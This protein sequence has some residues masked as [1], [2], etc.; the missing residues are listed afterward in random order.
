MQ[1]SEC[2]GLWWLPG[3]EAD[4]IAGVLTISDSGNLSLSLVGTLGPKSPDLSKAHQIILGSVDKSPCG[5]DVTL[6][7]C[8]LSGSN[9]GSFEGG[10]ETYHA[11]R[12]YFGAHLPEAAFA[13]EHGYVQIGGLTEW[14]HPLRGI[15]RERWPMP[16]DTARASLVSYAQHRGVEGVVPGG[17]VSLRCWL[18]LHETANE[19]D[20]T[21]KATL[22]IE[23]EVPQS[24]DEI[25]ADY[26]YPM[27]NLLTFVCDRAQEVE[28]FKVK[29]EHPRDGSA[30]EEGI[31]DLDEA[32]ERVKSIWLA[33]MG[34]PA[35]ILPPRNPS[36]QVIGP[37]VYP[38]E[39]TKKEP[40]RRFQMLFTLADV[41]FP[42][43][44]GR[45]VELTRKYSTACDVYFGLKYGPPAYVDVTFE[46][47]VQV[48]QLYHSRREDGVAMRVEEEARLRQVVS[49]LPP[50]DAEWLLEHLGDRPRPTFERVLREL[51]NQHASVMDPL[52]SGR[53]E[54]F[55]SEV[56]STLDYI[57]YRESE[58][59]TTTRGG[60]DL[61]WMME[62]LRFLIKSCFLAELGF[63]EAHRTSLFG[64]NALYQH[65]CKL[66][67]AR[68]SVPAEIPT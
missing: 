47:V 24:A 57:T 9:V 65:V 43:F 54:K 63:S 35:K 46:G 7:G 2:T 41:E 16:D 25:N 68:E 53:T 61:Y 45:W 27:Q 15:S 42:D 36:I 5:N 52:I 4:R 31:E 40:V 22:N 37:R 29:R 26:V 18:Q 32:A 14:A 60:A 12:G 39:V 62:K 19:I 44:I 21:E 10:R 49:L 1:P 34:Q 30:E 67:A 17:K 50:A 28:L 59:E 23:C 66:E 56:T 8:W 64:R 6:T 3:Q 58:H 48:L 38:E 11:G 20:I 13:F 33:R 51:V 55:V